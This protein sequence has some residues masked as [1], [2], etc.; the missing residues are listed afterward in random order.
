M[1]SVEDFDNYV[2][3][4]AGVN[5]I[6]IARAKKYFDSYAIFDKFHEAKKKKQ[7]IFLDKIA[8]N[9]NAIFKDSF[10]LIIMLGGGGVFSQEEFYELK[11]FL[12][13]VKIDNKLYII[14][15]SEKGFAFCFPLSITWDQL[16]SGDF[17]AYDLIRRP[18]RNYFV[19]DD[20]CSWGKYVS[21]DLDFDFNGIKKELHSKF[22]DS[23]HSLDK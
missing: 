2:A 3:S 10:D 8:L 11:E 6:E 18:S 14:E 19:F 13:K 23:I 12:N 5:S 16:L 21:S 9:K 20:S 4:W 15:D 22:L 7:D 1:F 17:I